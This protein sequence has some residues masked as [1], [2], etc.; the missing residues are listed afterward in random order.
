MYMTG[1]VVVEEY[2]L[3]CWVLNNP[4]ESEKGFSEDSS[5]A[6]VFPSRYLSLFFIRRR[7]MSSV[8]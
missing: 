1:N 8:F 5:G 6:I 3:L 2:L 7:L 4:E